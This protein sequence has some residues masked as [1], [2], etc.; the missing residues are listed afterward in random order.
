MKTS[1]LVSIAS[2]ACAAVSLAAESEDST[3]YQVYPK[4]L[5]RQHLGDRT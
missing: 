3:Q 2:I 1:L 4:N 5:A